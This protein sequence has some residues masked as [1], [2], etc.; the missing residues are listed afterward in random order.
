VNLERF[1]TPELHKALKNSL[2]KHASVFIHNTPRTRRWK[3]SNYLHVQEVEPWER[4]CSKL[5]V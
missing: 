2:K 3:K 4:L 1:E 5:R